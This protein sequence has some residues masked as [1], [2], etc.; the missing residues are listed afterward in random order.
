MNLYMIV[1]LY[2]ISSN[3]DKSS[4]LPDICILQNTVPSS[5]C[6]SVQLGHIILSLQA[7]GLGEA[8]VALPSALWE[9]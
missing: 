2:L 8:L 6:F 9:V 7:S 4:R 1:C 3:R 5:S